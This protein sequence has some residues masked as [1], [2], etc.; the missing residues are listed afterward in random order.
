MSRWPLLGKA[1]QGA[2]GVTRTLETKLRGFSPSPEMI[3]R[4]R[5]TAQLLGS[6]ASLVLF[7]APPGFGKTTLMLQV[8]TALQQQGVRTAW[9]TAD[10]ADNDV[11]RFLNFLGAAI[12][13]LADR[14]EPMIAE[15]S[16]EATGLVALDLI[17]RV[18]FA[19]PPFA[20]FIDDVESIQNTAAFALIRQVI[21]H[22]P[23][24]GR[25]VMGSRMLPD[26]GAARLLARGQLLEIDLWARQE[27][28][29]WV[30]T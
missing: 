11:G 5:L 23:P 18:S 15:E 17:D 12:D 30:C 24:G 29:R 14:T 25:V 20:L 21:E 6:N 27:V 7:A 13:A 3:T 9:L 2:N 10:A 4:P 16:T 19:A 28:L 22:L 8:M 26:I 1:G